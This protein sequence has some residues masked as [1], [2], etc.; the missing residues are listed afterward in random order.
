MT[1]RANGITYFNRSELWS[2][3]FENSITT[4]EEEQ[5]LREWLDQNASGWTD[6]ASMRVM[7]EDETDA[8]LFYLTFA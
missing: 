4:V 1:R 8:R 6:I 3:K 5:R 2:V 7:F